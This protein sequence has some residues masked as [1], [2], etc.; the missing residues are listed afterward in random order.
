MMTTRRGFIQGVL[1]GMVALVLP[2]IATVS[3]SDE[4]IAEPEYGLLIDGIDSYV[5]PDMHISGFEP[6][7]MIPTYAQPSSKLYWTEFDFSH[8]TMVE[9]GD[10][11][12]IPLK[13]FE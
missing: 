5:W 11:V 4:P 8:N 10:F 7:L 1:A 3:E 9:I 6:L 2:K 13:E 12:K